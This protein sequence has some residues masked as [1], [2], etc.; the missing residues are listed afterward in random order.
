[1]HL[2]G[3]FVY[4]AW[5]DHFISQRGQFISQKGVILNPNYV[6]LHP[7]GVTLYPS[8]VTLHPKGVTS[9]P[10]GHDFI[11]WL[12]PGCPASGQRVP[13]GMEPPGTLGCH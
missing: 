12:S 2:R 9:Y 7:K 10:K 1:M 5:G 4:L 11:T 8:Y 13:R 3:H 6:T